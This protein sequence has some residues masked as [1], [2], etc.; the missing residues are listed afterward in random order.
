MNTPI[1]RLR[2][3]L[4]SYSEIQSK[5]KNDYDQ[6]DRDAELKSTFVAA[7]IEQGFSVSAS[8][9]GPSILAPGSGHGQGDGNI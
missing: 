5:G 1:P 9:L 7:D 4:R 6:Q 2:S 3:L 8:R